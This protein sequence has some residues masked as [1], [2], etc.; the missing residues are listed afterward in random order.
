MSSGKTTSTEANLMGENSKAENSKVCAVNPVWYKSTRRQTARCGNRNEQQE[1]GSPSDMEDIKRLM[2]PVRLGHKEGQR[3]SNVMRL[4]T[5]KGLGGGQDYV[6]S[7]RTRM[8]G[9]RSQSWL[10]SALMDAQ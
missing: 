3:A 8:A 5:E 9:T 10:D 7:C 1:V 2:Q 6:A 4:R